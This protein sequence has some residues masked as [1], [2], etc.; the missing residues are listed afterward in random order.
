MNGLMADRSGRLEVFREPLFKRMLVISS[1]S[2]FVANLVSVLVAF[3]RSTQHRHD[4]LLQVT[5]VLVATAVA[6]PLMIS[7]LVLVADGV[8]R[9]RAIPLDWARAPTARQR[10]LAVPV[11]LA[12]A[13]IVGGLLLVVGRLG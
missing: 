2:V 8:V 4:H 5:L 12:V 3:V 9:S 11:I 7:I 10:A 13:A 1:G 6:T